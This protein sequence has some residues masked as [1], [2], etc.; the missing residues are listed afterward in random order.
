MIAARPWWFASFAV[1]ST[2]E[3]KGIAKGY[4]DSWY[5]AR[6][7][8]V[9]RR[10]NRRELH[11]AYDTIVTDDGEAEMEWILES[12][13]ARPCRDPDEELGELSCNQTVEVWLNEGWWEVQYVGMQED[14]YL[15]RSGR[16][17][18]RASRLPHALVPCSWPPSLLGRFTL[19]LSG[20]AAGRS[21]VQS[22]G[23]EAAQGRKQPCAT[24]G[25]EEEETRG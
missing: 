15:V 18:V 11:V 23:K 9:R 6:V 13:R 25:R 8:E 1:G 2:L 21:R 14:Q 16:Y 4:R 12:S 7:T 10:N 20:Q 17:R 24:R 22:A 5:S 3:V 19:T